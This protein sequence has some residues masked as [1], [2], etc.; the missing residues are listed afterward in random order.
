MTF[1][2]LTLG[3]MVVGPIEFA[4]P[5]WLWLA[6]IGWALSVWLARRSLSGLG[7]NARRAA[8][9]ARLIVI[10]VIVATLAEPSIRRES[11]DLAVTI[12]TDRSRSVPLEIQE[13]AD[14]WVAQAIAAHKREDDRTGIVTIAAD[15]YVQ[16]LPS[17]RLNQVEQTF[18]GETDETDLA[19]GVNLALAMR[20]DDAAYRVAIISDGNETTGNLLRQAEQARAQGVPIDVLILNFSLEQETMVEDVVVSSTARVGETM[21][22][23]IVLRATAPASGRVMLLINGE[24]FDLDP[25]SPSL[26]FPVELEAGVNP[27]LTLPIRVPEAGALQFQAVFEPDAGPDGRPMDTL[28]EN[29]VAEATTFVAGEGRALM[30]YSDFAEAQ[31][32]Y[33]A[34]TDARVEV[35]AIEPSDF[36]SSLTELNAYDAVILVNQPVWNLEGSEDML[37]QYI[38]DTG[39]GLVMVGG[40]QSFGAGGWIGSRLED[41]LPIRLDPPQKRQ[42]P[43]GALALVM[44]SIEMPSGVAWGKKTAQAAVDT[45]TRLDLAGIIEYDYRSGGCTWVHPLEEVGDRRSLYAAIDN[46]TFGDMPD[47]TPSLQLA[48]NGL[49]QADAAV[50]H[51]IMI[52]DGDPSIQYTILQRFRRAQI[53]ISTVGVFPHSPGDLNSLQRIARD[54]GGNFYPVTNQGQL[55]NIVQIF[56][57]EAQTVKRPLIWE[58]EPFAPALNPGFAETMGG[59]RSTPRISGYVVAGERE[60]LNLVTIRGKEN[61]PVMA[62][63]QYGLGR[64]VTYT[65]D[66]APKWNAEW[67]GWGSYN[68]FWEQHVRWAMRP[69]GNA[70]VRVVTQNEG[71]RTRVIVEATDPQGRR[72]NFASFGGRVATPDGEGAEV[73]LKQTGPGRYEGGFE[74]GDPGSYVLNLKYKAPNPDGGE[75]LEGSTQAAVNRPFADEF[76]ATQDNAALLRQVA[77]MTGGRVLEVDPAAPGADLWL[78][79]GVDKPVSRRP[80]WL[81]AALIALGLFLMDVAIRRVRI[82]VVAIAATFMGALQARTETAGTQI[83]A[84]RAARQSARERLTRSDPQAGA[85][86]LREAMRQADTAR[87]KFEASAEDLRRKTSATDILGDEP[88]AGPAPTKSEPQK[89]A[90]AEEEEGM[91]RLLKAKRRAQEDYKDKPDS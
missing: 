67:M 19:G 14:A 36:P 30:L 16:R 80:I 24:P 38:H 33:Q 40:D 60:G 74:S 3:S 57:K 45:L 17:A 7:T 81:V 86:K 13:Q 18:T 51:V 65:S 12:V 50:K 68:A 78:H 87:V 43:K 70:N 47:F 23:R 37:R 52:S 22:V 4:R 28:A 88:G 49:S 59:I 15:A 62:Q 29:N 71:D 85:A 91:S 64:V 69:S 89:A 63:W 58:G 41:A 8:L 42:M 21:N 35:R 53:T 83:D 76:R 73:V 61:D 56:I 44:H 5:E 27:P 32:L 54:T 48:L 10:G 9:V 82:D 26:G 72:L 11:K 34:L 55:G 25:D 84:L 20:P 77:E 6:L 31:A 1:G 2:Q 75:P 90:Q 46:L 79:E 39:G 66:A